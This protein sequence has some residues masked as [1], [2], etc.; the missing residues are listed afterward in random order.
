MASTKQIKKSQEGL[1]GFFWFGVSSSSVPPPPRFPFFIFGE[2]C[3]VLKKAHAVALTT[4][5]F[6]LTAFLELTCF[7]FSRETMLSV[8]AFTVMNRYRHYNTV[9]VCFLLTQFYAAAITPTHNSPY[10]TCSRCKPTITQPAKTGRTL[11]HWPYV[12]IFSL[13]RKLTQS[14][15]GGVGAEGC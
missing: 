5:T 11:C 4:A 1:V 6:L 9:K 13:V 3:L 10:P 14:K 12:P 2:F 7:L 8:L 15:G